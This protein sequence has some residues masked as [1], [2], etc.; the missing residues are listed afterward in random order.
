MIYRT[1]EEE[2]EQLER[3]DKTLDR[4][5]TICVFGGLVIT[6]IAVLLNEFFNWYEPKTP[7]YLNLMLPLVFGVLFTLAI[8]FTMWIDKN[9]ILNKRSE[10]T[11]RIL[12][13]RL[14][15]FAEAF[16]DPYYWRKPEDLQ[17]DE[18]PEEDPEDE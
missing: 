2:M 6:V 1:N 18:D 12:Q 3:N 5:G 15:G 8:S 14:P 10:A 13:D 7:E 17:Q 4:L 11:I 16:D 9:R